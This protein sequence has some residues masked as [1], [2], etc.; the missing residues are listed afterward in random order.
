MDALTCLAK[1]QSCRK[2]VPYAIKEEEVR[3]I[4][5]AGFEAPSAMNR[6]PYEFIVNTENAFWK[7]LTP[8]KSTCAIMATASL[9]ILV[10]GNSNINPTNEFLIEDASA[11]TENMLLAAT[12]LGFGSLWAGIKWESDFQKELIKRFHLPE[13]YLPLAL[14]IVGK[15]E[16]KMSQVERYDE[17]KIHKGS[18]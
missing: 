6:R 18:F 1:R 4:L 15:A 2:F 16:G 12:A 7:E 11:C 17:K 10:V 5:E 13:G 14:V 8:L 9:T 3:T